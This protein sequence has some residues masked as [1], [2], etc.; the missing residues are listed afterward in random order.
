M[1][2]F[3][4]VPCRRFLS[5]AWERI[6]LERRQDCHQFLAYP[7]A[8]VFADVFAASFSYSKDKTLTSV[9]ATIPSLKRLIIEHL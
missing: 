6:L 2:Y 4:R 3:S 5:S 8:D 9:N 7:L 1:Q